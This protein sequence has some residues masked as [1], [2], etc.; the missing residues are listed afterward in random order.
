MSAL[1][2]VLALAALAADAPYHATKKDFSAVQEGIRTYRKVQDELWPGAG[3]VEVALYDARDVF[4]YSHRADYPLPKSGAW[5]GFTI[6]RVPHGEKLTKDDLRGCGGSKPFV[7][8]ALSKATSRDAYFTCV[9]LGAFVAFQKRRKEGT[10]Y[11]TRESYLATFVHE[12]AHVYQRNSPNAPDVVH[13][14]ADFLDEGSIPPSSDRGQSVL[15]EAYAQWCELKAAEKLFPKHYGRLKAWYK[16][17][18]EG[19]HDIGLGLA[20]RALKGAGGTR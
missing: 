2:A 15:A 9:P 5:R 13:A 1:A 6:Y 7:D 11:D 16:P 17:E 20:L 18:A 8:R 12:R 19:D 14:M 10:V 4:L 3:D